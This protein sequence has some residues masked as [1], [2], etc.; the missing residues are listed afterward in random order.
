MKAK[1]KITF[2][3]NI[4]NCDLGD[5]SI[6]NPNSTTFNYKG[7]VHRSCCLFIQ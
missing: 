7:Y 5:K 3:T 1:R 2:S 6:I 4:T